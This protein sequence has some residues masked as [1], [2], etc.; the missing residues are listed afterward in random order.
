MVEHKT[1]YITFRATEE[2]CD[3]IAEMAKRK[4][5][6]KTAFMQMAIVERIHEE[7]LR[8]SKMEEK[9]Q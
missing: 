3:Q 6:N 4:G 2:L 8:F 9:Y 1:K 7:E 5:M